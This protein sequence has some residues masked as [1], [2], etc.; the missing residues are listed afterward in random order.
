MFP[1]RSPRFAPT[2]MYAVVVSTFLIGSLSSEAR[3][4][5]EP[6]NENQYEHERRGKLAKLRE[7]GV[8]PYGSTEQDVQ[9]LA[10]VKSKYTAEMGHDGGPVVKV[11]G[12]VMLK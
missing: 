11:A 12:R 9:P 7:I 6:T 4:M 8:D 10:Q 5:N 2:A 3:P 1:A